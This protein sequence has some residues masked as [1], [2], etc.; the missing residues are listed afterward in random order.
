MDMN[1]KFI[2]TDNPETKMKL[3]QSGYRLFKEFEDGCGWVFINSNNLS[4]EN[5]S[6]TDDIVMS[7][8]ITF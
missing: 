8:S 6:A 3:E 2:Y 4:F 1:K 5:F 7:D